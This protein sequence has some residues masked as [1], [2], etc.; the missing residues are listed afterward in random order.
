MDAPRAC[1]NLGVDCEFPDCTFLEADCATANAALP[2]EVAPVVDPA[3]FDHAR[4]L[5]DPVTPPTPFPITA[6]DI[7]GRKR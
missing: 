6:D 2:A 3:V 7:F 1:P 5:R 4:W